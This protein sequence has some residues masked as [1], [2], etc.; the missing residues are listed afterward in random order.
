M[1]HNFYVAQTGHLS[2]VLSNGQTAVYETKN[3]SG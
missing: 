2:R 3:G 1:Q